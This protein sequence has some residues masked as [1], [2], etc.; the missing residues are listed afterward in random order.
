M[1]YIKELSIEFPDLDYV[2]E[3]KKKV[4]WW[5][6]HPLS[7][8][9]NIHLQLRNWFNIAQKGFDESRKQH[10]IGR[11]LSK[12]KTKYPMLFLNGVYRELRKQDKDNKKYTNLIFSLSDEEAKDAVLKYSPTEFI[13]F[14]EKKSQ[15]ESSK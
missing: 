13:K 11:D 8:R 1:I 12:Y 5:H 9:S 4:S 3:I 15:T 7:K 10:L 6:D 2:E 14:L